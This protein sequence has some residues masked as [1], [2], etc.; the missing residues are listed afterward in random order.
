[1][2]AMV[3]NK[4]ERVTGLWKMTFSLEWTTWRLKLFSANLMLVYKNI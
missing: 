2:F 3:V 1:M 4:L